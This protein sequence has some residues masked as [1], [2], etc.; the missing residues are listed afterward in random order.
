MTPEGKVK[1]QVKAV[2]KAYEQYLYGEWPVP[3]GYGKSG[4][5]FNGC[6]LGR[7]FAIET[8]APGKELT[9]RQELTKSRIEAAG[10]KVFVIGSDGTSRIEH[11][12][13]GIDELEHWFKTVLAERQNTL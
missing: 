3:G 6:F 10:G 11:W 4:L 1:K 8:K 12:Y 13:S 5:D 7:Y 9:P 2:I